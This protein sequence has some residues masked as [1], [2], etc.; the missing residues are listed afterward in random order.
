MVDALCE[1]FPLVSGS[2]WGGDCIS[3]DGAGRLG[4]CETE[5]E[6]LL[7]VGFS[8]GFALDLDLGFGGGFMEVAGVGTFGFNAGKF[9]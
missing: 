7:S 4:N 5:D 3:K 2:S 6:V 1:K 9:M 8:F